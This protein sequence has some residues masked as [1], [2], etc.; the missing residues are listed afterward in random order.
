MLQDG[1]CGLAGWRKPGGCELTPRPCPH[2]WEVQHVAG[3]PVGC[4]GVEHL[5]CTLCKHFLG[6]ISS[7]HRESQERSW[8]A[9]WLVAALWRAPSRPRSE[10]VLHLGGAHCVPVPGRSLAMYLATGHLNRQWEDL[11]QGVGKS[12][13]HAAEQASCG[14]LCR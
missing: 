8:C 3:T 9:A 13:S 7:S 14:L 12:P 10:A 4:S 6:Y 5:C 11:G 1:P 2:P